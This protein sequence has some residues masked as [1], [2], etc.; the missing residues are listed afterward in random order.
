MHRHSKFYLDL[1]LATQTTARAGPTRITHDLDV[2]GDVN[3]I[4]RTNQ[5][6]QILGTCRLNAA[7]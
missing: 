7:G 4:Y 6:G 3:W 2:I 5:C 1:T